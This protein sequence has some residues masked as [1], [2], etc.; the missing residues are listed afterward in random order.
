MM[1]ARHSLRL[2][3]ARQRQRFSGARIDDPGTENLEREA[4]ERRGTGE[5]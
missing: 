2:L 4:E 3:Q 5:A 1:V